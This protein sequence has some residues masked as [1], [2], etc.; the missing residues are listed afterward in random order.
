MMRRL[1]F[2]ALATYAMLSA[3]ALPADSLAGLWSSESSFGPQLRGELRVVGKRSLW[4]ASIADTKTA[5]QVSGGG[6]RFAFGKRG[7]FRGRIEGSTITG[8][9][10]QPEGVTAPAP[11]ASGASQRFSSPLVLRQNGNG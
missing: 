6:V 8:S 2:V 4:T 7:E 5:F 3:S 9:W 11:N 10:L 1:L